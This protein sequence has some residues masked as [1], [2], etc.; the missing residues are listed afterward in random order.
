MEVRN[1]SLNIKTGIVGLALHIVFFAG[2][3]KEKNPTNEKRCIYGYTVFHGVFAHPCQI[4]RSQNFVK[5]SR[6]ILYYVSMP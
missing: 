4:G 1:F 2:Q 5:A 6:G 3:K